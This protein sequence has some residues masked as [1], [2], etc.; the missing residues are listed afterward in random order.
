METDRGGPEKTDNTT[1]RSEQPRTT[2]SPAPDWILSMPPAMQVKFIQGLADGGGSVSL[3]ERVVVIKTQ[4]GPE[5]VSAVL[6]KLGIQSAVRDGKVVIDRPSAIILAAQLPLFFMAQ[7]KQA[8][9][10][11][12]AESLQTNNP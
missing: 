2:N 11:R 9:L 3:D 1:A 10:A 8:D 12:L 6:D 5:L 4:A 7:E